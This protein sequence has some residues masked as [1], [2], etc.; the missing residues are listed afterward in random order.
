MKQSVSIEKAQRKFKKKCNSAADLKEVT[1]KYVSCW[2]IAAAASSEKQKLIF[3]LG[4]QLW[5]I[6]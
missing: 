4:M 5:F 1:L 3:G 6:E 2:Y